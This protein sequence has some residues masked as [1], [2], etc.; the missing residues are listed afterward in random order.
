M[1]EIKYEMKPATEKRKSKRRSTSM[2]DPII[3]EFISSG[4]DLV[5][6]TVE[7]REPSYMLTQLKQRIGRRGLDIEVSRSTDSL[8]LEKKKE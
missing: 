7:G 3:D 1:S 5:E 6:V 2:F 4:Y 8:Y